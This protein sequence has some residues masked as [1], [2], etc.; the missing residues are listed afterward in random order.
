MWSLSRYYLL[1]WKLLHT[2]LFL[3]EPSN[4]ASIQ[5]QAMAAHKFSKTFTLEHLISLQ[6]TKVTAMVRRTENSEMEQPIIDM[7][8]KAFLWGNV[9]LKKIRE[10]VRIDHGIFTWPENAIS[11]NYNVLIVKDKTYK[12]VGFTTVCSRKNNAENIKMLL[13]LWYG[14]YSSRYKALFGLWVRQQFKLRMGS[15]L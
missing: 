12:N 15:I 5:L 13:I 9:V 14:V 10:L 6:K 3:A 8:S 4:I 2:S 1:I 7:I 11:V